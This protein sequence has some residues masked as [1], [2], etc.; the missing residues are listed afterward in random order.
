MRFREE[1]LR[2]TGEGLGMMVYGGKEDMD[3]LFV[4][5]IDR[6]RHLRDLLLW[7]RKRAARRRKNAPRLALFHF[8]RLRR[9]CF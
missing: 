6:K 9:G 3:G 1:G 5:Q 4:K 8:S 2:F 7:S